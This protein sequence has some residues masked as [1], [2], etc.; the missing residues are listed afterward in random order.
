MSRI[1]MMSTGE[2]GHTNPMSGVA[3]WLLA[4]GHDVGWLC[5]P[6]PTPQLAALGVELVPLDGLPP[7]PD[8]VTGGSALADLVR[9]PVALRSWIRTLLLDAVPGHIEPVRAA[10]RRFRP[11]VVA[12]DPMLYQGV[13][14]AHAEGIPYAG[15]SSSL[16]PIAPALGTDLMRTIEALAPQRTKLFASHGLPAADFRVCDCVSPFLNTV[17]ATPAFLGEVDLP[18][19]THLVGPSR[20]PRSGDQQAAHRGDE[21]VPFPW[22]RL[23]GDEPVIYASFGSQISW[24]PRAFTKIAHAA[25]PLGVTLV[26]SAGDLA[27]N[28]FGDDLP[29]DVVAVPYAPQLALLPRVATL[30]THGGANSVM[31]ALDAGVPMLVSPVCND[32]PV[33]AHFVEKSGAGVALDLETASVEAV[34]AALA[35]LVVDGPH[36]QAAA[37]IGHD[38]RAHDGARKAAELVAKLARP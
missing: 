14:A 9:D 10:F 36:R 13:L 26:L 23:T 6:E 12:L 35:A 17:F 31:E 29:G 8:L 1:L 7:P 22:S 2:K 19:H 38:Y 11:D 32:Q 25:A 15:I 4:L 20:P 37:R 30:V 21:D 33:Q 34:R 16:N 18:P 28:G 3:T 24:Q 5:I 27:T